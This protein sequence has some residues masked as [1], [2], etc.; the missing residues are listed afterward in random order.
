MPDRPDRNVQTIISDMTH[1]ARD[2]PLNVL[3]RISAGFDAVFN[4]CERSAVV[5]AVS[6][7]S[8]SL[9]LLLLT[10]DYLEKHF[11][12]CQ[13]IA[14]TVDHQLRAESADEAQAVAALCKQL[15]ISHQILCWSG[16]KP[17]S[18]LASAARN[19][20]Y[21]LL[22]QAAQQA[23]ATMILTGHTAD[24]QVETYLMRRER[25]GAPTGLTGEGRGLAAMAGQTLLHNHAMLCRPL[26]SVW[27]EELRDLLRAKNIGWV[28]DP[29]NDNQAY[30]RPRIRQQAKMMDKPAL[31]AAAQQVGVQRYADNQRVAALLSNE[32][33]AIRLQTGD[34][35]FLP[36]GWSAQDDAIAPL[37]LS[38]LLAA[39]GGQV[40]L[41]AI[42]DCAL[43]SDWLS[44]PLPAGKQRKTLH[45]CVIEKSRQGNTIRRERRNLSAIALQKGEQILWDGRYEIRND[46]TEPVTI[47]ALSEQQ[48]SAYLRAQGF[49]RGGGDQKVFDRTALLSVPAIF[50]DGDVIGLPAL[51]DIVPQALFV[52][53]KRMPVCFDKVL[54]GYDFV[55][56][57]A[58]KA[59][60][61][62]PFN[63]NYR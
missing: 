19:A 30:E 11:P 8:D 41:P 50:R 12:A 33:G 31:L 54:S 38:Y 32:A 21:D 43:L 58:V 28:D 53:V 26:L 14:V 42:K 7:G 59:L 47:A 35:L 55:V 57:A 61:T 18:G 29:S 15:G 20:R 22:V 52:T 34:S 13:L 49:E 44:E 46:G 40:F 23:Q 6:G 37:A 3:Q 60:L 1:L 56:A 25:E 51:S 36:F 48:L 2:L 17:S 9:A 63:H 39:I 24:D 4:G 45:H 5:V 27:R 62:M 16:D 10:K